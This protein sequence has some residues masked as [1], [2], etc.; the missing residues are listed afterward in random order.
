MTLLT[1]CQAVADEVQIQRPSVVFGSSDEG[2]RKLLRIAQKVGSKI[3]L[4][5]N[6][7]SLR[8]ELTFT[9]VAGETQTGILPS[10]FNRFIAETFWNRSTTQLITGPISPVQW[11]DLKANTYTGTPKFTQRGTSISILPA[12]SAGADLAFEYI[13]KNWIDTDSDGEGDASSWTADANDVVIDE[14]LLT[15]GIIYQFLES[16][17]QPSS[18]AASDF[19]NRMNDLV[20]NEDASP[21]VLSV[22]DLFGQGGR[23]FGGAPSAG[24]TTV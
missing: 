1:I 13:S 7:F 12:L 18:M 24:V 14:E 23:H 15:L 10:D 4:S 17:G 9:S 19:I 5:V 11:Q 16:E 2:A 3:A 20:D 8:K 21:G 6:W 22:G